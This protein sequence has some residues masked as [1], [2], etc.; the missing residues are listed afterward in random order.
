M[1]DPVAQS[2]T[3]SC[4][5]VVQ[6]RKGRW[7]RYLGVIL[8]I[9]VSGLFLYLAMR[10][11]DLLEVRKALSALDLR[12]LVPMI[13]VGL[14]DFWLRAV[15]WT[16]MFPAD[17]RPTV[18]QAFSSFM[19]G[20]MTNNIVPGRLGD[21]ARAGLIAR[22]LPALGTS[23]AFATVVLEKVVDGL[24][25]LALLGLVFLIAP[26]PLW[27]AKSGALGSLLFLGSLLLLFLVNAHGKA[28]RITSDSRAEQSRFDKIFSVLKRLLQRFALGL[29]ALNSKRQA[30]VVLILA[31]AI[32]LLEFYFIFLVFQIF[33]LNLPFVAAIV[34][35]VILCVG[36]MLPAAP[37][38]IGTYQF[39]TVTGLQLYHVPE[40]QALA[41]AIFLN[42]FVFANSTM[43]GL[44]TLSIEGVNWLSG[45]H[46]L[47]YRLISNRD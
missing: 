29:S 5:I 31:L 27:L 34:T 1:A 25:L 4:E 28:N 7:R 44:L 39:F 47:N 41:V 24:V 16:W 12:W 38:F 37:G 46:R 2:V 19:L 32:W 22:V 13:V 14:V 10:G 35:G 6:P 26:L 15:R 23:G 33:S 36:M 42:L 11:A 9:G 20:T 18:R 8:C 21:I 40:S 45:W 30:V 43:L 17:S 3:P